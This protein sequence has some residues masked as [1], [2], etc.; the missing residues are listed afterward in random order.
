MASKLIALILILLNFPASMVGEKPNIKG[1]K[2]EQISSSRLA[3]AKPA[4]DSKAKETL[5]AL[6]TK[7]FEKLASIIHPQKGIRFEPYSAENFD[8]ASFSALEFKQILHSREKILWGTYDGSGE[9]IEATF[10]EYYQKFIYSHDFAALQP[11]DS[12][13]MEY[14]K[15]NLKNS[16]SVY[17]PGNNWEK[18]YP[19]ARVFYYSWPDPE[20]GDGQGS[21]GALALVFEMKNNEWYLSAIGH[22]QWQI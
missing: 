8:G 14:W 1:T 5:S 6:K 16:L 12:V 13:S 3:Q 18:N 4:L 19:D 11:V 7:N 15:K 20:Y 21:W 10:N 9:P 17:V 2:V 22:D